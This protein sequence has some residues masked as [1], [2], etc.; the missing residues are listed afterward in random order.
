MICKMKSEILLMVTA[1]FVFAFAACDR[2]SV[3]DDLND[4]QFELTDHRGEQVIFPDSFQG[5]SVLIGYVYTH[6]PDI[7]PMI[8]FN[9]RDV[10]QELDRDDIHFVS[11]SFDPNRDTPEILA[12]YA[13]NYR[14]N[15]E[16][17][18]LLTGDRRTIS[19]LLDR[20]NIAT[21]K[22]PSRFTESGHQIYFIDHTDRVTLIDSEGKIRRHYTGSEL[23]SEEV[24]T[25]IR[26]LL[27][28]DES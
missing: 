9:M 7:C 8:T 20:L 23:R 13:R 24:I 27:E 18:S 3:K 12:D 4:V 5:K 1:V 17:W 15:D 11:I 26:Q 14:L 10:E 19:E 22:T 16:K 2:L 21:V 28:I 25:D 6:C